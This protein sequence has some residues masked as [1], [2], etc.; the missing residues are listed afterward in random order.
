M[1]GFVHA[2]GSA[3]A[4]ATRAVT[5]HRDEETFL[6]RFERVRGFSYEFTETMYCVTAQALDMPVKKRKVFNGTNRSNVLGPIACPPY[7]P[8]HHNMVPW[9]IKKDLHS[10]TCKMACR[11][12]GAG[13]EGAPAT[14]RKPETVEPVAFHAYTAPLWEELIHS[15]SVSGVIDFNAGAG[16]VAEACVAAKIPYVGFVQTPT[17]EKVVRRYLYKRTWDLM[18]TP[19]ALHFDANLRN[20]IVK[21]ATRPMPMPK[22]MAAECVLKLKT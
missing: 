4:K 15:H 22:V 1:S 8:T 10:S 6:A 12:G 3:L 13:P 19:G 7:T 16:Y 11:V 5:L 17:H 2:D 9:K 20:L 14:P 21:E 18:C